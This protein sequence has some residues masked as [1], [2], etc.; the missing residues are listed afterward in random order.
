M[1]LPATL[2]V[3]WAAFLVATEKFW[4]AMGLEV[5]GIG[6]DGSSNVVQQIVAGNADY[7]AASAQAVYGGALEGAPVT[8]IAMLTH[9]DVAMLSVPVEG[10]D[11]ETA[12]DLQGK[13]IG[14]T[15]ATD[16]AI[17]IVDAVMKSVGVTEWEQPIVGAGGA[18][19]VNAFQTGQIQ[20]FA[21]GG[22]DMAAMEMGAG[23]ELRSIM[24]ED[25]ANLP[26][27]MMVVPDELLNDP[28]KTEIAIKLASGWLQAADWITTNQEE[29][30]EIVCN[31]APE[32]CTDP[33][34]AVYSVDLASQGTVPIGDRWGFIDE[35]ATTTLLNAV[36]GTMEVPFGEVFTNDYIDRI[37]GAE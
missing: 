13:S 35:Q 18:A 22:G 11:I 31:L 25:F 26:G 17:P 6:T 30:V 23:M 16:G 3:D 15:S 1:V 34:T 7:G 4:P 24:P 5:N 2:G 32:G 29:A 36:Y 19:V 27:N 33:E 14:V 20:A 21:H 12:A 8:A 28:A 37:D 10:S 9:G